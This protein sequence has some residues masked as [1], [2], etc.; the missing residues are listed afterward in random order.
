[1][2][3]RILY[4]ALQAPP[5]FYE[6][7]HPEAWM[8]QPVEPIIEH[9][10][11]PFR[12]GLFDVG[13]KADWHVGDTLTCIYLFNSPITFARVTLYPT[14]AFIPLVTTAETVTMD[15]WYTAAEQPPFE[16]GKPV[17]EGISLNDPARLLDQEF[18]FHAA[19]AYYPNKHLVPLWPVLEGAKLDDP[20]RLLDAEFPSYD[21]WKAE[22]PDVFLL[23][24]YPVDEGLF[25][26]DYARLLDAEF[27]SFDK[28]KPEYP[29]VF[30]LP[31]Y[32]VDEGLFLP[33]YARLLDQEFT[34]PHWYM[35]TN[36][37]VR[38]VPFLIGNG[39]FIWLPEPL[40]VIE[41]RVDWWQPAS[42]PVR[43]DAAVY[44]RE[45]YFWLWPS[46]LH[47]ARG[48]ARPH[49]L[50]PGARLW[51]PGPRNKPPGARL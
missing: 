1:M 42:E 37:P 7:S 50:L 46:P 43:V 24:L 2:P 34:F 22:Y 21:K 48:G 51:R 33:D 49:L 10:W 36:E 13:L 27:P 40:L 15:M 28:W 16:L 11:I 44:F 9:S 3:D 14:F 18:P 38:E 26:P 47:D 20:A 5:P 41:G 19:T 17:D 25:L 29:D 31:R 32:P 4:P 35:Q 45:G 30:L 6:A 12:E 8:Q 39:L 23:P